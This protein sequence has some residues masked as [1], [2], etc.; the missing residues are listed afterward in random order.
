MIKIT[1]IRQELSESFLDVQ[2]RLETKYR[3]R[4][5][6]FCPARQS[7]D[8]RRKDD[9]HYVLSVEAKTGDE[10]RLLKNKNIEKATPYH[11]DL[12]K[13]SYH[14]I[15]PPVVVGAG[16]AGLFAALILAEAG[17]SPILL[18]RGKAVEERAKDVQK[19]W[20][21]GSLDESS[22]VQFGEGGAGTFSDGKLTTGTKDARQKKVLLELVAGG[23]PEDIL[24]KAKPH[25]GTDNLP[26]AVKG[27]R[28]KIISLGGS[29]L[30]STCLTGIV[31]EDGRVAGAK[32]M[33]GGAE[34]IIKT[35]DIILAIGHSARD[36]FHWLCGMGVS[37]EQKTFAVGVRVEH[38]QK[39][40]NR[41]R[42]GSA[43]VQE[44]ADYKLSYHTV[45]GRGVYTFCMCPGGVVVPAASEAGRLV[46]NGMSHYARSGENANSALLVNVYPADFGSE[47]VLAGVEFQR[48]LEEAAYRV[49]GD[50][51]APVQLLGDFTAG[52]ASTRFGKVLPTYARG[53]VFY[54]LHAVLPRFI[55]DAMEEAIPH[56]G[57]RLS[58]F[59]FPD[60]VFTAVESRS[61]SPVRILRNEA[62][63]S[64][65]LSGLFPA[66]EGAGYAGGIMSAAVDGIKAAE[67]VILQSPIDN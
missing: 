21:T 44:A 2:A 63:E 27:I 7:L 15:H 50:Y 55:T 39:D 14:P 59:D 17:L 60:A 20:E 6:H 52:K 62:G 29:V 58:G 45:E 5:T 38:L 18:E 4:F 34:E 8:A 12:P 65:T 61:S 31:S 46:T 66:G 10:A 36:T 33:R 43:P 30:F 16:P 49:A 42:Y 3:T 25:V 23:A 9:V 13:G 57:K 47:D 22:N 56:L 40:I 48:R 1:N 53:T 26:Q 67:Q 35:E 24:Y 51:R 11:Y 54:D 37:M 28:E 19:F 32:V 64:L 41:A